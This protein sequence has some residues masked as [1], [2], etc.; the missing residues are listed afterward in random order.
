MSQAFASGETKG[1][2]TVGGV[3]T[4][5][6]AET[7]FYLGPYLNFTWGSRLSIQTGADLPL[8]IV[9]SGDQIV[10]GYRVHAAFTWRF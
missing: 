3:P 7:S 9:S 1:E 2:D 5:D 8:S 6:T 4:D 10:P